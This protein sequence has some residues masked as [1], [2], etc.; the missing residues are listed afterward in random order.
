[1]ERLVSYLWERGENKEEKE[2]ETEWK[3]ERRKIKYSIFSERIC[4][5]G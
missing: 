1:M 2:E 5:R 3:E 4:L